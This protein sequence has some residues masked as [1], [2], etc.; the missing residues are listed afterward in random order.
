M[1]AAERWKFRAKRIIKISHPAFAQIAQARFVGD[2]GRKDI[3]AHRCPLD[4]FARG[5]RP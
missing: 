4:F 5:R 3:S 1:R 2:P